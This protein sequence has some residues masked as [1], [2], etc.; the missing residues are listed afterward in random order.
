MILLFRNQ[1]S[2]HLLTFANHFG[3]HALDSEPNKFSVVITIIF[4]DSIDAES[5]NLLKVAQNKISGNIPSSLW[6]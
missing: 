6:D 4:L 1:F 2:G 5:F 3:L